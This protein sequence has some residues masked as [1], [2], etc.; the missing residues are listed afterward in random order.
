[1]PSIDVNPPPQTEEVQ[2]EE[3]TLSKP[4]IGIIYPPPEVRSILC[5]VHRGPKRA[6]KICAQSRHFSVQELLDVVLPYFKF[7]SYWAKT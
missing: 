7:C 1:M 6:T 2:S 3:A 5:V 4:V